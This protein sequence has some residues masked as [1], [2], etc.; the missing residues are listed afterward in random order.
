MIF[1][2]TLAAVVNAVH[3]PGY[4]APWPL[5]GKVLAKRQK[6]AAVEAAIAVAVVTAV[7]GAGGTVLGAW[8]Q[9]RAQR[10]PRRK[11]PRPGHHSLYQ[12]RSANRPGASSQ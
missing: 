2:S 3:P 10:R 11:R 8:V 7:I 4:D 1:T 5:L 6:G 9:G 12:D